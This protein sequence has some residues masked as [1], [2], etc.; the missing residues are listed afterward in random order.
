MTTPARWLLLAFMAST[1]LA[2]G[3]HDALGVPNVGDGGQ[4]PVAEAA[5]VVACG[6]QTC[7]LRAGQECCNDYAHAPFC[8]M[9]CGGSIG[10]EL[11]C[12]GAEDCNGARCC[13]ML[14]DT[15]TR[16]ECRSSCATGEIT[17]CRRHDECRSDER[18][19]EL[20][21]ATYPGLRWCFS[22]PPGSC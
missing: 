2:A 4:H 7:D 22:A 18:C 10:D 1:T 19:C 14:R 9:Q 16:N 17:V 15:G 6:S 20:D 3:C 8:S 13:A 5:G 12:D 21:P 11:R